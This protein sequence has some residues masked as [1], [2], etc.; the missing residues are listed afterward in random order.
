MKNNCFA[1]TLIELMIVMSIVALLMAI[2]G[3]MAINNL[4]KAEAKNELLLLKNW[5]KKISYRAY[6]SG[7]QLELVLNGKQAKLKSQSSLVSDRNFEYLFF[8]PQRLTFS[9]KGFVLPSKIEGTYKDKKLD[10][11]LSKM[12]NSDYGGIGND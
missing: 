11:D 7:Q 4:N 8:H 5:T 6:V 10:L 9:N 1:F 3:P 2:V 12:I